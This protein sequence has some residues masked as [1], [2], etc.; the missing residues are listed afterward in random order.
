MTILVKA[1]GA[2]LMLLPI[3]ILINGYKLRVEPP[4]LEIKDTSLIKSE[5]NRLTTADPGISYPDEETSGED[6]G[7]FPP[8]EISNS[9]DAHP[10]DCWC[11]WNN[12]EHSS[13]VSYA[14]NDSDHIEKE[15]T[16]LLK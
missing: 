5:R 14:A 16:L 15:L 3:G 9:W 12:N 13:S 4:P 6:Y 8:N 1:L 10:A 2:A 11:I 7:M